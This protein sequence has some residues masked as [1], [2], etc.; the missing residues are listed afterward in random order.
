MAVKKKGAKEKRRSD[1]EIWFIDETTKKGCDFYVRF[2]TCENEV[3]DAVDAERLREKQP[4]PLGKQFYRSFD[5]LAG[6]LAQRAGV[7]PKFI[8]V[9]TRG[10]IEGIPDISPLNTAQ[11]NIL[12]KLVRLH[13]ERLEIG[14]DI[15]TKLGIPLS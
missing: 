11:Y 15:T 1:Q 9:L 5:Q 4:T 10:Q 6:D 12:N 2:Y 8:R 3:Y 13:N 7:Q 14:K